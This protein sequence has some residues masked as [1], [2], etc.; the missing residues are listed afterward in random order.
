MSKVSAIIPAR[1][2]PYLR[3]TI[4]DL[5]NNA[6]GDIEIIVVL[7]GYKYRIPRRKGIKVIRHDKVKG[8]RPS[9][10]EAVE[11][12]TG[13]YIMKI[14]AH[15]TIGEGWDE[16][17]QADCE[18]NWIVIPRR[19]WFDAPT[20]TVNRK[21]S[22]IDA[23]SYRY[24]FVRPYMPRLTCRPDWPRQAQQSEDDYIVEDMGFQGS[25]WFMTKEHFVKRLGG[26]HSYG[27]GTFGEEPQENGLRTQL[28]PWEGKVM[29]NKRTW[30]A[31]WSK[32]GIHW[33][34][35]PEKA[36]RVTDEEREAGY[37]YC[38]D[39]W[40][41]NRWEKQIHDFQWLV[42]K[43][44]P[45]YKWPDNWRWLVTQYNRHEIRYPVNYQELIAR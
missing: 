10:N 36:G 23:M 1:I 30:Y 33:R 19:Y 16:I 38:W 12:A 34:T 20:W 6:T 21:K 39:Y 3:E 43:F 26:M 28:G 17:L 45:V 40:W 18:D 44:W 9:I 13:K 14:D 31:H 4:N 15:C 5:Y 29:R 37:L 2:E 27:Y 41:N 25:C 35:D 8:L 32:P 42:D 11:M 24:P 7:D 22:H